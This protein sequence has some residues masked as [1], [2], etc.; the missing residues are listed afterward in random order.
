MRKLNIDDTFLISEILDKMDFEFPTQKKGED[1]SSYGSK[2]FSFLLKR[3]H[4]AKN[5]VKELVASVSGKDVNTLGI[6]EIGQTL[7][8]IAENEGFVNFLK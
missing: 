8:E 3:I 4:R 6:K 5:E 1:Q 2:V 7:K